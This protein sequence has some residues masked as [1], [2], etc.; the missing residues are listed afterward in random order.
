M[1]EEK[2][3][4][5][6]YKRAGSCASCSADVYA[7]ALKQSGGWPSMSA[8]TCEKGPQ[9]ARQEKVKDS[10]QSREAKPEEQAQAA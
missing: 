2:I 3:L 1:A 6:A 10:R 9:M 7:P 4:I 8:C 5:P